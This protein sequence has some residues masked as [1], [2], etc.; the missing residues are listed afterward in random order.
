MMFK[1]IGI[2]QGRLAPP[3]GE[4]IQAFPT[5]HWRAE[6]PAAQEAGLD[7]IEWIFDVGCDENN[8]MAND[9]GIA[10]MQA[11][12]RK[13]K[14][15][16]V[17]LCADYFM[18][19][20][21]LKGTVAERVARVEKLCWLFDRCEKAGVQRIVL[22]FVDNSKLETDS[23]LDELVSLLK[24]MAPRAAK[25]GLEIHLE[26][27]LEP[28]RFALLLEKTNESAVKVNYDSGNSAALGF[29]AEEE[30]AAY[31]AKIGSVH[32]KDRL[33][34][35][36]TVPLGKGNADLAGLRQRLEK[37]GYEG[38]IILQVARGT[39]GDEVQWARQNREFVEQLM[40]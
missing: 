20:P 8:P 9:A 25:A 14:I 16:I 18:L 17:S 35:G 28:G 30:F 37:V 7:S 26:T 12:A 19:K 1:R 15:E 27:S 3:I 23:D 21:L 10:E 39:S 34:H 13:N 11:L 22:P 5:G 32:I 40:R 2:M 4:R 24:Q 31:G 29:R 6:F 36:G 38:D 33:L